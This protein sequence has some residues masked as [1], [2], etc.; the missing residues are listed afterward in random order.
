M[1]LAGAVSTV[2]ETDAGPSPVLRDELKAGGFEDVP[3]QLKGGPLC[4]SIL[5]PVERVPVKS[6]GLRK[7]RI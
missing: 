5:S 1:I 4:I 7:L 6:C 2:P 3:Q